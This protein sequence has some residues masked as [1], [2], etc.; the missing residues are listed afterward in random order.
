ML[1]EN[2]E[3][4]KLVGLEKDKLKSGISV[5]EFLIFMR[6]LIKH[7]Q[8]VDLWNVLRKFGYN[9]NVRLDFFDLLYVRFGRN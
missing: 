2:D 8:Q 7:H 1:Y 6:E 3:F 9:D 4:A 5:E